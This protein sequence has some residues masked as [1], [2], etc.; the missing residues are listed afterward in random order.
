MRTPS[1]G[2]TYNAM[3]MVMV[4]VLNQIASRESRAM[5]MTTCLGGNPRLA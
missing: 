5:P 3:V 2:T 1:L 4:M